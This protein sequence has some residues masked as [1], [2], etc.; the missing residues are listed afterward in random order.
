MTDTSRD[1]YKVAYQAGRFFGSRP[2][3][4]AGMCPY[5][6]DQPELRRAW[7]DGFGRGRIEMDTQAKPPPW[8]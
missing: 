4:G 2:D 5:R 6:Q 1:A 3:C 8:G 7:M